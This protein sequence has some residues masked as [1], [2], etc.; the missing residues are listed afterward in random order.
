[1]PV[2]AVARIN[3]PAAAEEL[4]ASG[5]ADL[6]ML[7]RPLL[8]DPQWVEKARRGAPETIRPCLN[9]NACWGEI[10]KGAPIACAVNPRAG[11][12]DTGGAAPW[13]RHGMWWWSAAGRRACRPPSRRHGRGGG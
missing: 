9:C 8:A 4:L 11:G 2:A 5:D 7:A 6:V 1:M 3:H 12:R 10:N 13:L